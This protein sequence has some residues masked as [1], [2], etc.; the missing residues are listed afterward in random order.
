MSSERATLILAIGIALFL[1]VYV[2]VV[3]ESPELTRTF[4]EVP[5]IMDGSPAAGLEARLHEKS[6]TVDITVR[7]QKERVDGLSAGEIKVRTDVSGISDT[8]THYAPV[9]VSL[10]DGVKL[11]GN[12]P[13]VTV[14]V[15]ALVRQTFPVQVSFITA[16]PTGTTIGEYVLEPETVTVDGTKA[17]LEGVHAVIL[18]VDPSEPMSHAQEIPPRPVGDD[19][20]RVSDVRVLTPTVR[21]R[22]SSFTGLPPTR[23]MA[24]HPPVL[25]DVPPHLM[26]TPHLRPDAVT[27]HGDPALFNGLPAY[28]ECTPLSV[29]GI[30]QSRT[31][32][33]HLKVP[34]GLTVVEGATVHL[35]LDVHALP[36]PALPAH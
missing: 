23:P 32:T 6:R 3:Q 17:A 22:M 19:G 10:P 26:I 27:V 11:A 15:T 9:K 29:A 1:W 30:R 20:E 36:A 13:T 7:G 28:L 4:R 24:V 12:P 18:P 16:P 34:H 14:I 8:N 2:R 21:V 35:D 33:A 31:V 25:L 5:V